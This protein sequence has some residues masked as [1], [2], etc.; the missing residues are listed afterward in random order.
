MTVKGY[1]LSKLH[2][3]IGFESLLPLTLK[4]INDKK[5]SNKRLVELLSLHPSKI[6]SLILVH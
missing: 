3:V 2:Q 5:L 6:L 1:H 4:L